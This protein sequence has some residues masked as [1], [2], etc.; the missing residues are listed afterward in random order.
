[1]VPIIIV[2]I[3]SRARNKLAILNGHA[4]TWRI[5]HVAYTV[6]FLWATYNFQVHYTRR[7]CALNGFRG[8]TI[9]YNQKHMRLRWVLFDVQRA[10]N[11]WLGLNMENH[12]LNIFIFL[13]NLVITHHRNERPLV[14]HILFIC[15]ITF[16]PG[17]VDDDDDNDNSITSLISLAI[18]N[19]CLVVWC[20][21]FV[22]DG[23]S[24]DAGSVFCRKRLTCGGY[25]K[26][27]LDVNFGIARITRQCR[28]NLWEFSG[29]TVYAAC[30]QGSVKINWPNVHWEDG[31]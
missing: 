13:E 28:P 21:L 6:I 29:V 23:V 10:T 31:W 14:A 12:N 11:T 17:Y 1:M 9:S 24:F 26:C 7:Q 20:I 27:E 2:Q 25:V 8:Y 5:Y 3:N 19:G 16:E 22:C 18:S 4:Y 30:W 15:S